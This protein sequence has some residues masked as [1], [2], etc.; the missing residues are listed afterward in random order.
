MAIAALI[1]VALLLFFWAVVA[2]GGAW[3]SEDEAEPPFL[4]GYMSP[5]GYHRHR[6]SRC[7]TIWEHRNACVGDPDAHRC[8]EC[9]HEDYGD[10]GWPRY[11]GPLPPDT[12]T[13]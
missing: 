3:S 13:S 5:A 1:G 4:A 9:G 12:R 11:Y 7:K 2:G 8:P 6:C 10:N